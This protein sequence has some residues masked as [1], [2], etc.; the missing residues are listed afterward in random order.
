MSSE[1]PS[2]FSSLNQVI[3]ALTEGNNTLAMEHL[4]RL[5]KALDASPVH[6]EFL[7]NFRS[8]IYQYNEGAKFIGSLA[9]GSLEITPPDDPTRRNYMI[10]QFKQLHSDLR[11]FSWQMQQISKGD[12][13]QKVSF[14]GDFSVSFNTMIEALREK[15]RMEEQI[16]EQNEQLHL[17]ISEKDKIFSIIGHDLKSPFNAIVGFSQLL[18]MQ[19]EE[20]DLDGIV[21]YAQHIQLASNRA[22][23]LLMNLLDW[24]RC[25]TGRMTYN[26]E[27]FDLVAVTN[28]VIQLLNPSAEQKG[29]GII[30][31]LP[32]NLTIRADNAMISTVIRNLISNAIKFTSSG[33]IIAV[34]VKTDTSNITVSIS[35][36][37]VG[38]PPEV[39]QKLFGF[40][41][42]RSTPGTNNEQGTGLG[43][44]LCKEFI[45]KHHGTIGVQ[46]EPGNG[47]TFYFTIPVGLEPANFFL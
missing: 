27:N 43:L 21:E 22:I 6:D 34:R 36:T 45:E 46:S 16:R 41:G 9:N 12:L 18:T 30:A 24:A 33:G 47:S 32:G 2:V 3:C 7:K 11:H 13:Q 39:I 37:G 4:T 20:N 14:L 31:N 40:D 25:Q 10:A 29:I 38:I 28:E 19:V 44:I 1:T 15:K 17:L 5:E 8:F 42:S 23:N 26:P 35:D